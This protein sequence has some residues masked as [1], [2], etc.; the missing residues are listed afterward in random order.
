MEGVDKTVAPVDLEIDATKEEIKATREHLQSA[1]R[2][3]GR[4]SRSVG[5][6]VRESNVVKQKLDAATTAEDKQKLDKHADLLAEREMKLRD[7][8]QARI[9]E[10]V[11]F[12]YDKVMLQK[13]VSDLRQ[14]KQM[15]QQKEHLRD[16]KSAKSE[17][18]S[19]AMTTQNNG[20]LTM[21]ITGFELL[22]SREWMVLK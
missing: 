13:G 12:I 22:Q 19:T 10:K 20:E 16:P 15:L 14:E 3:I 5:N 1:E 7:E 17:Q 8:K 6:V 18:L 21:S 9:N 4:I 2:K 11:A